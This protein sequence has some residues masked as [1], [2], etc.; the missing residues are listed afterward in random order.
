MIDI[1]IHLILFKLL[2]ENIVVNVIIINISLYCKQLIIIIN[3][4]NGTFSLKIYFSIIK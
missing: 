4:I 1:F 3:I 2:F